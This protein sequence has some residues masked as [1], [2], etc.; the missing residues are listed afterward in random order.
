MNI[1]KIAPK[2]LI[3]VG[4]VCGGAAI[5]YLYGKLCYINGVMTVAVP[6]LEEL[7]KPQRH[8]R[9]ASYQ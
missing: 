3:I 2:T 8:T 6:L 1:P 9:Y 7:H 4:S 5:L